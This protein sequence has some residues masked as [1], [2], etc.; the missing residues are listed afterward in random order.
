[1]THAAYGKKLTVEALCSDGFSTPWDAPMIPS[2]PFQ[3]RNVEFLSFAWRTEQRHIEAL[4]PPGLEATSD[5][6]MTHVARMN[7]TDWVGPFSESNTMVGCR[8]VASGKEG[9][10]SLYLFLSS[11]VGVTHGREVHGQPKKYGEPSVEC[12]GDTW[13]GSVS[14]NGIE[15]FTGT[16]VYKQRKCAAEDLQ[17]YFPFKTNINLKAVNHIDGSAAIRQLTARELSSVEILESWTAPCTVELR[18]HVQAPLY[19]LPVVEMLDGFYWRA[20]FDLVPGYIL[21]DYL[22]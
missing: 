18:P 17:K 4:L 6:V 8:H 12:R 15:F 14:R 19:R 16:M 2:F 9:G 7:D 22:S 13:V 21:H 3:F 10:Y 1:M 5:V 11:D 20:N